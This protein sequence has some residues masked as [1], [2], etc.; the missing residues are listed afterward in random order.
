MEEVVSAERARYDFK[1]T[2]Q[3]IVDTRGR[4]T[5]L[6]SLYVPS[7]KQVFDAMAYLRDEY[8][9]SSNIKSKTTMKNVQSAI[10]SIMSRLK[11]YKTIP[12]NGI[13]IFCGEIPRAGDQTRMVQY[14]INPPEEITTF[15][16]RCDSQFYLDP[17]KGMLLDKKS[18]G[19]IVIDR[20][21]CTIGLLTGSRIETLKHFDSLIMGK[22][23]QG[24]Q[25]SVRFERL[26]EIA[27]HEYYKKVSDSATDLFLNRPGMEGILIGGPG[28]TKDYFFREGYLHHE[29]QKKVIDTFDTGYTD[30]YGLKEL[31]ENAKSA[32]QDM[33]LVREKSLVQRLFGEIRKQDGGLS[34]YGEEEVRSALSM[35]A[36]D[37]LLVSESLNKR[38]IEVE[39]HNGHRYEITVPNG[40]DEN[41]VC[42]ECGEGAT[43][44]RNEDI[45]DDFFEKAEAFNT[46]VEIISSDS[47]EGQMLLTA[48]GGI[49]AILRYKVA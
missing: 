48:F 26:I 9:Q 35:G 2:M 25:S 43:I 27:A 19:L 1:K 31:V 20:N 39:C 7:S 14:V 38:R 29:L 4:G 45:V 37:T 12:P 15:L 5:E 16:Y 17:L 11:T 22:H 23:R 46:H 21:E 28:Y 18:Y 36:V 8:S 42:R 32:I 47:E 41:I 3:E 49:A 10:D 6:I 13:A 44:L 33:G 24:G 40:R 34:S 30:E